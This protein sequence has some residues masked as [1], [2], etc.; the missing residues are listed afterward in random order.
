MNDSILFQVIR[1]D[2]S[3]PLTTVYVGFFRVVKPADV[4]KTQKQ[5]GNYDENK[6]VLRL[7]HENMRNGRLFRG[8]LPGLVRSSMANGSSMVVYEKVHTTLSW[9]FQLQRHDLT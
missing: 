5:S 7:L 9:H 1:K 8:L 2:T 6:S 4:V 3:V